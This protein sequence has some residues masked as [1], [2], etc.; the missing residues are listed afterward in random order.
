MKKI[1]AIDYGSKRVGLA[2]S[3]ALGLTAQ[4]LP[5]IL[6]KSWTQ[7]IADLGRLVQER[8]IEKIIVG[9]PKSPDGGLG[10][11]AQECE[12][13]SEAVKK[14]LQIPVELVD[15]T[16]TSR[17]AQDILIGE[18]NLSREKRKEVIDSMAACLLLR[19][20]LNRK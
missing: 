1:L 6:H 18:F 7:V 3:D 11:Q 4:P 15:E 16:L 9:L 12:K 14:A 2:S 19:D 8:S 17:E 13:F 10:Q 20:Y 5:Y